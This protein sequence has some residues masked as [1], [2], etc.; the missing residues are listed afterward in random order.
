ML[1]NRRHTLAVR[2]LLR[3][4]REPYWLHGSSAAVFGISV[5][6][7]HDRDGPDGELCRRRELLDIGRE[8]EGLFTSQERTEHRGDAAAILAG[9][10]L[11]LAPDFRQNVF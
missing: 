6:L 8:Q 10:V 2:A 1:D 7:T 11:Q 4:N 3:T 9:G 5:I